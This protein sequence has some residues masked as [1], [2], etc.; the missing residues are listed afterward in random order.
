M[1]PPTTSAEPI[2]ASVP[3]R[4]D[5]AYRFVDV[6]SKMR[7]VRSNQKSRIPTSDS[8]PKRRAKKEYYAQG[9]V[10]RWRGLRAWRLLQCLQNPSRRRIRYR[11]KWRT[12][13]WAS[14]AK[15]KQFRCNRKEPD[16]N[17]R[18]RPKTQD[19]KDQY[20]AHGEVSRWRGPE[21]WCLLQC[22]QSLSRRQI[23]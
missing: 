3:L 14:L 2:P 19:E 6:T 18:L 8:G 20:D 9:E 23:R 15:R 5:T 12:D 16:T 11:G 17:F 7:A 4:M 13:S 22:L 21:D 10:S 1:A